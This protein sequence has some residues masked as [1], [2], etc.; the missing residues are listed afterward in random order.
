MF[1]IARVLPTVTPY[2]SC[3]SL[4][5]ATQLTAVATALLAL[6]AIVT[7]VFALLAFCKQSQE[8]GLLLDQATREAEDRRKAQ[9][10]MVFAALGGRTPDMEGLVRL[11]N[12]SGQPIYDLF[13]SWSDDAAPPSLPHLMPGEEHRFSVSVPPGAAPLV[14]RLDFR[15]AAGLRWRTTSRG[16]LTGPL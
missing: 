7:A 3:M 16:Q 9:A 6:F 13:A 2:A 1:S 15:D 4:I 8:V 11:V 5:F 10:A 14:L 12:S